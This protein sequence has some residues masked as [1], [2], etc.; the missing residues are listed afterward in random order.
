MKDGLKV[1]RIPL[2]LEKRIFLFLSSAIALSIPFQAIYNSLFC[3]A[4]L[5]FWMLFMGKKFVASRLII[6]A[7]ISSLFWLAVAGMLYTQNTGEGLFR[8]QQKSLLLILPLVFGTVSIDWRVES[9]WIITC[10]I[11]GI[12]AA[13]L[14]SLVNALV[15]TIQENSTERF[16][17]HGLVEFI[18][19][20]A[21]ILALLCLL[22]LL[23]V[24]EAGLGKIQIHPKLHH[25]Y[26][27]AGMALF[28]SVFI[29]LLSVKQIILTWIVIAI[30][31][32]IRLNK[33]KWLSTSIFMLP[34][35]L[36]I[37]SVFF[38][39]TLKTKFD[40]VVSGSEN[41]IPLDRDASLGRSWNGIAVRKALWF[42]SL[43]VIANN[44]WSGVGTGDGQD[45]LQSAYESRQ[46]YF[47]SRYNQ[48]NTHNQ[49]LQ[50]AVNFGLV[51]LVLCL[52]SFLL[53]LQ[54][55]KANWFLIILLF[56]LASAML[57]ESMLET[58]KGILV[59]AFTLSFFFLHDGPESTT[60][61]HI[62]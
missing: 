39:P 52:C 53:L 21:Y 58:N 27:I 18:D 33:N 5:L 3:I 48:F 24:A 20:Y 1:F 26:A 6:I 22:A 47:A 11:M 51:G 8:L 44:P 19:L 9:K 60:I 41:T 31:Y 23:I 57:T 34:I 37:S 42:C 32:A 17:S 46:F 40:E 49:Y 29:L 15:F 56:T 61:K 28:L 36:T 62:L 35:I 12:I 10:F 50:I 2:V 13:C 38:V 54:K 30:C 7:I 16:F 55:G 59:M 45:Q 25:R 14:I 4:L 43:D